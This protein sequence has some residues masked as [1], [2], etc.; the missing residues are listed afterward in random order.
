MVKLQKLAMQGFKSFSKKTAIPLYPGFNA[1]IGPNGNGKSNIIDAIVFVLGTS[2]RNLRADRMQHVIY[3]GGHGSKPADAAIVSLVL[4]NSDK[5]LKEQGDIVLIS[6]R[7]NRRGNSVYRLNGKA[8]NRRKIL[9]LMGEAHIDPEGYNIIQQGDIT[10][11]IGMKPKERREIVDEAAGIKEYNEKKTKALKELEAAERNV[12]DAEIVI[13]QKKEFLDRLRLDRDAALKYNSIMDKMDLAKATLAFTRVKGV[14]GAL[15]NVSRNLS[16][17]LA[18]LGAISGNVDTFDKDLEALEKQVDAFNAEILKK[19]VNAGARRD[20]EEIRA[21]LLKKEGEIEANRREVDRLEEMIAKINQISQSSNPMGAANAS[22]SAIMGLRKSGVLGS[23]S[24]IYRTAPKYEAA[25]EVALGGHMND[26]VVDS[27]HT[28][29]E[30]INHLKSQGLGRVRFLPVDRLRPAVFSAKAEVAA[31]MPGVIDFALNLIKF[32]KKYENAFGDILRDTLVSEDVESARKIKGLKTV[33]L[34]GELFE[35]GGAIVGGT[36]KL[37]RKGSSQQGDSQEKLVDVSAYEKER[38]ELEE[39]ITA[40]K[41]EIGAL[42]LLLDE[43]T[44]D[45]KNESNDVKALEKERESVQF[46]ISEMK[47]TRRSKYEQRLNLESEINDLKLQKARLETE[48]TGLMVDYERY[49]NRTDLVKSDPNKLER[50][51]RDCDRQLRALGPVNLKAIDEFDA[52]NKDYET[53]KERFDKLKGEKESIIGMITQIEEK[54]KAI[55]ITALNAISQEF[56]RVFRDLIS[57]DAELLMENPNDIES[58]L[59][60][61]AQPK[62]K[63]LLSIDLLSGGEKT[64]T[65][66]AFL[67][68]IQR[69]RPSPFYLLDEIDAALDKTNASIVGDFLTKYAH[70]SQFIVV[71]HSDVTVKKSERVYGVTMQKGTSQVFGVELKENGM[72]EVK[73]K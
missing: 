18:E 70:E 62:E 1:V 4:D 61:K 20:V 56:S 72:L 41:K 15:E 2:S 29:I 3:N 54:R 36:L 17:K 52:L 63:K 9:D 22:V 59:L 44:A 28:A 64:M 71:S 31:K 26:V 39:E 65:A 34:E 47:R 33:T 8:V 24:S 49:K 48:L 13:G 67:F 30:C 45:E 23:I 10:G 66:I 42:N 19:S 55:F 73:K 14:E 7:V 5:T 32:D 27:E 37:R 35:S 50:E 57:G 25:I 43:K 16:I 60:I 40:I 12:S 51:I 21:K 11:L 69:F 68:A 58:G 38:D 6:R 46:Q 53:F